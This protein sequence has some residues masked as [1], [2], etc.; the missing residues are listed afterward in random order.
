MSDETYSRTGSPGE[1]I[2]GHVAESCWRERYMDVSAGVMFARG[3]SK[4]SLPPKLPNNH[5]GQR[6]INHRN[7]IR[8]VAMR[9]VNL[10]GVC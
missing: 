10:L 4:E 2:I 5:V 6:R 8:L 1:P 3:F 7:F 9:L